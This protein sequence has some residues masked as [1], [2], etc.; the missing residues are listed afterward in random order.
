MLYPMKN[1]TIYLAS[2][3]RG[4][5]LKSILV[6]WLTKEG[7]NPVDLGPNDDA[8]CDASS[9]AIK[10]AEKLGTDKDARGVLICGT[11]QAMIM[12]SNRYQHVRAALCLNSFMARLSRE[13]NNANVLVMGAELVG[14]G[15]ALDVGQTF[16]NTKFLGGRYADRC[17]MLTD[18]GGL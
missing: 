1:K 2:D 15:L 9:Y 3:H 17:Q 8:R 13:H 6:S 12:T 18:L 4:V 11:G 14:E 16:F 5:G 10:V 7:F